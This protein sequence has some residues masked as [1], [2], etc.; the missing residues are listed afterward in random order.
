MPLITLT[1]DFGLKDPDL[2]LLKSRLISTFPKA[3]MIDITHNLTPFETE[4][5]IYVVQNSLSSFP[6]GTFHFIGL[7]SETNPVKKPVLSILNNQYFL[8]ND[9]ALIETAFA[10]FAPQHYALPFKT[11]DRF[12]TPH[13]LAAK[14]ILNGE[15]PENIGQ[16][17]SKI[18]PIS[19]SKPMIKTDPASGQ[20]SLIVPKVI[21]NDHYGNA[22]F[23][24]KKEDF[25]NWQNNRS[26]NIKIGHHEI[27]EIVRN[28]Y[29]SSNNTDH[30]LADGQI[31]ARFND[32]GYFEIFMFRS[33]HK[34]GGANT[35]LGLNKNK[36]VLI[37]FN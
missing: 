4:E 1:T 22:I 12:L 28:Y 18:A 36:T 13:M 8:S 23:N 29:N 24:L 30:F 20:I 17:I 21:Y 31:F 14:K 10:R 6:A 16:K 25:E 35:L 9:V 5:A 15:K 7:D 19:L 32:F 34:T 37:N 2:A 26:F 3:N 27:T 33:N 11:I